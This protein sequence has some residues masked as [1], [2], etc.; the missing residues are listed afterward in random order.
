MLM[1][2]SLLWFLVEV[3]S[4]PT[5]P[6]VF[7]MSQ[8]LANHSY[9]NFSLIGKTEI[10]SVQ[11]HTELS[12]CCSKEQGNH[13][14]DWYFPNGNR[15]PFDG[16]NNIHQHHDYQRVDLRRTSSTSPSG[17]YQCDIA[18]FYDSN[19]TQLTRSRVYVGLYAN[20]GLYR[21]CRSV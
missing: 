10:E 12:T 3:H 19:L 17:M 15:L 11:C 9:V 13:R 2:V 4:R 21:Q 20:G 14:G 1:V 18:T 7:F 6:Y 8:I 5:F 16:A